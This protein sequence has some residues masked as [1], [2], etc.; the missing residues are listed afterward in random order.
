MKG[1]D[2]PKVEKLKPSDNELKT[3][4]R[5]ILKQVDFNTVRKYKLIIISRLINEQVIVVAIEVLH[6]SIRSYKLL[7]D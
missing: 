7:I 3:A 1:K 6:I 5:E 2:K 4:I